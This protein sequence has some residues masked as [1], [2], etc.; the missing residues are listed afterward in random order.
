MGGLQTQTSGIHPDQNNSQVWTILW[1]K[2]LGRKKFVWWFLRTE[3]K[4][5]TQKFYR[6]AEV[7][8][9]REHFFYF[10]WLLRS[11]K[12]HQKKI[13]SLEMSLDF[14][15]HG[16]FKYCSAW[17][18]VHCEKGWITTLLSMM[19]THMFSPSTMKTGSL[20]PFKWYTPQPICECQVG[21]P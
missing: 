6:A 19:N 7:L 1:T 2:I 10:F 5:S 14:R 16:A 3:P 18:S 9:F 11:R 21:F 12:A 8:R 17:S 15:T 13:L 4:I 20:R